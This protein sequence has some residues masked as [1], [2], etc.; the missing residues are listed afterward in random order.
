MV[1]ATEIKA[2]FYS[3]A[4]YY[5]YSFLI[6]KSPIKIIIANLSKTTHNKGMC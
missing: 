2:N 5:N 6:S 4:P 1:T 3:Y